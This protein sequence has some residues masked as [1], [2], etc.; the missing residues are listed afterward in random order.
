[1]GIWQILPFAASQSPALSCPAARGQSRAQVTR[2][3][4]ASPKA[5][6][7]PRRHPK[8]VSPRSARTYMCVDAG[9]QICPPLRPRQH[10]DAALDKLEP[11]RRLGA[12]ATPMDTR[13]PRLTPRSLGSDLAGELQARRS[14]GIARPLLKHFRLGNRPRHGPM[15]RVRPCAPPTYWGTAESA[16]HPSA[17]GRRRATPV[18][19]EWRA[20]GGELEK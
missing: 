11:L 9:A 2:L 1:M 13:G 10:D 15:G 6:S 14:E 18:A 16:A 3:T 19:S 12:R 8:R 17:N 7:R 4:R 5:H 20:A